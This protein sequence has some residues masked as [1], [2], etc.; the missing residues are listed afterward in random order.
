MTTYTVFNS[1]N[2]INAKRGLSRSEAAIEILQHDSQEFTISEEDRLSTLWLRKQV[3][4]RPW[5]KTRF[6][7]A[8]TDAEEA[9][10]DIFNQVLIDEEYLG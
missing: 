6:T 9:R 10:D 7:S 3:A 5:A 8:K 2:H 1:E 4:N